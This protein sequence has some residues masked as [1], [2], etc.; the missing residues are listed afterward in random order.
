MDPGG[1][2]VVEPLLSPRALHRGLIRESALCSG[3]AFQWQSSRNFQTIIS[4]V[5]DVRQCDHRWFRTS[6]ELTVKLQ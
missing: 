4:S 6:R 5:S 3:R 2:C 1:L